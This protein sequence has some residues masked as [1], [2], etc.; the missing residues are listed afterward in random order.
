MIITATVVTGV[1]SSM[2][3]QTR[4]PLDLRYCTL[5]TSHEKLMNFA[6]QYPN[7]LPSLP[8]TARLLKHARKT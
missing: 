7:F 6:K 1:K 5:K 3:D 8:P 4:L 2:Y